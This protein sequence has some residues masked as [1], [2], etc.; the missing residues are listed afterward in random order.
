MKKQKLKSKILKTKQ[1]E[2][3][4]LVA[5]IITI[6]V[7]LILAVVAIGAVKDSNIIRY[8]Q[9]A[10]DN[11]NIGKE[12][13]QIGL[14]LSEY[15]I[16]KTITQDTPTLFFDTVK[17][18]LTGT[19]EVLDNGDG[20]LKVTI[21][22]T[23]NVY[24]VDEKGNITSYQNAG[25]KNNKDD[26]TVTG[27]FYIEVTQELNHAKM[28]DDEKISSVS[29]TIK[30]IIPDSW[31]VRE[32]LNDEQGEAEA[33]QVVSIYMGLRN[34]DGTKISNL[35]ELII[36]ATND[37]YEDI[38]ISKLGK[39]F[40]KD[41][42]DTM[43]LVM[44]SMLSGV[45]ISTPQK[46]FEY[47]MVV[48]DEE[49]ETVQ[50]FATAIYYQPITYSVKI[51]KVGGEWID[52]T[53][54]EEW[55]ETIYEVYQNG[56]YEIQM[57]LD[58]KKSSISIAAVTDTCWAAYVKYDTNGNGSVDDETILWRVL[59]ND[60]DKVELITNEALGNLDLTPTDL[61]DARYKYNNAIDLMVAECKR[62]T[63]ITENIRNVGG[64]ATDTTTE[65]VVFRNLADFKPNEGVDFSQYEATEQN[66]ENGFKV[67]MSYNPDD[68]NQ[69]IK[70][71]IL[72]VPKTVDGAA[73]M[74]WYG[75]YYMTNNETNVSFNLIRQ[76]ALTGNFTTEIISVRNDGSNVIGTSYTI[77][78]FSMPV[79]PVITLPAGILDN[80]TQSGESDDPI[81]VY[82]N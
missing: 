13:E 54:N 38:L 37:E 11:Y 32:F 24:V 5:L 76:G 71:G 46:A 80:V 72:Y 45:D 25:D 14:A 12:Q 61:N 3:I 39:L 51:R 1:N 16:Q 63:G 10:G 70:A 8:A 64:P 66:P 58:D 26:D 40:S 34:S 18:A 77:N 60:K 6:V 29:L 31:N 48:M 67:G 44:Q 56:T 42:Y 36:A 9:N 15:Q 73:R 74:Y 47:M 4:T 17:A 81:E 59:R 69:M 27:D 65:T 21:N 20:T 75:Q 30:P 62:V 78:V 28:S 68:R 50:Q 22:K 53:D 41:E 82:Q 19:A 52:I 35:K 7:L 49:Y 55:E 57:Q 23:D 2:G 33:A 43:I 79:R